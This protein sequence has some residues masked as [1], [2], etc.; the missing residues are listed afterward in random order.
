MNAAERWAADLRSWAIPE[1]ILAAAPESPFGFP[2]EAFR[3]RGG[4]ALEGPPT[5]TTLRALETLPE[6]GAVLDV[7]AGGG[8]TSLPLAARAA[9][10]TDVDAQEDM[11]SGFAEAVER[12]GARAAVV[13]GSWPSI[14]AAAPVADVVVCGHVAYNVADLAP[15]V[16]AL[17]DHARRR[18]VME[19]TER[20]PLSWMNDLWM[21]LHDV[22]RPDRP[23]AEDAAAVLAEVGLTP[24]REERQVTDDVA[25]SGFARREDAIAVVRR[26]LCLGAERDGEIAV[27]LGA[28]L[29]EREGLWSAGPSH[30]IVVTL[31]WDT[32]L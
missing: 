27:A 20:H 16:R 23:S 29:R 4:G 2:A 13:A 21:A 17:H 24:H 10:I 9:L 7:G 22:R 26:R 6:G 12:A 1:A 14:D 25:G 32:H 31:W 19:L 18:V 5:P 8:A 30:Q 15:F 3:R 11:L 28:R